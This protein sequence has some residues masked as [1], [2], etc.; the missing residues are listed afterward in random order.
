MINSIIEKLTTEINQLKLEIEKNIFSNKVNQVIDLILSGNIISTE[1]YEIF[2]QI[3]NEVKGLDDIELETLDFIEFIIQ[4][5]IELEELQINLLNKIKLMFPVIDITDLN[6]SYNELSKLYEQLSNKVVFTEFDLL[7][8][9]LKEYNYSSKEIVDIIRGLIL[10]NY[11][12][13]SKDNICLDSKEEEITETKDNERVNSIKKLLKRFGLKSAEAN[14]PA[15]DVLFNSTASKEDIEYTLNF[16]KNNK[17]KIRTMFKKDKYRLIYILIYSTKAQI[18]EF[19]ELCNEASIDINAILKLDLEAIID[20]VKFSANDSTYIIGVLDVIRD[21]VGFLKSIGYDFKN[22]RFNEIYLCHPKRM[23][24]AYHL[25]TEEYLLQ[26]NNPNDIEYLCTK[27]FANSLD[28]MIE[29]E[30]GRELLSEIENMGVCNKKLYYYMRRMHKKS[31]KEPEKYG[32]ILEFG[33]KHLYNDDNNF[34][35]MI[36]DVEIP[37]LDI[38]TEELMYYQYFGSD[39]ENTGETYYFIPQEQGIDKEIYENEYVKYLEENY[40]HGKNVY[41]FNGTRVSKIKLLR[42]LSYFAQKEIEID[43]SAVKFALK[44]DLIAEQEDY[45]NIDEAIDSYKKGSAKKYDKK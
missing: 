17:F 20:E 31:R 42:I 10:S 7:S 26:L 45:D 41:L 36:L 27:H 25:Y 34:Y 8:T 13:Y 38:S 2:K 12:D 32:K 3:K 14:D 15:F 40:R 28:R 21:N 29:Y 23:Q 39:E 33:L 11:G 16:Y 6:N 18:D 44:F 24:N 30:N 9:K 43:D 19:M 22:A 37:M 5:D 1:D 35:N 4:G